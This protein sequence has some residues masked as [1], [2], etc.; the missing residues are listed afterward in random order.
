MVFDCIDAD[1][2]TLS[3]SIQSH[4]EKETV[5]VKS[6]EKQ[7]KNLKEMLHRLAALE[8]REE[9]REMRIA[10]QEDLIQQLQD[11]LIIVQGK[12]CQ[13][14]ECPVAGGHTLEGL[15]EQ[16]EEE[17]EGLEYASK[18]SYMTLPTAPLEL[19]DIITQDVLRFSTLPI[20][21]QEGVRECCWTRVVEF[22]DDLVEIAD[23]ERSKEPL[24]S[25]SSSSPRT[26]LPELEDQENINPIPIPPPVGNPPPYAVSG[27]HAV[28]SKGVPKSA[29]H[30][31]HRPLAQLQC[32]KATAGRLHDGDS[33]W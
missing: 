20:K 29:F 9:E 24:S 19:E 16:N 1:L 15:S 5:L 26:S 33:L 10:L 27:Q 21:E 4:W 11:E 2:V 22:M 8:N 13:C 17:E 12:V 25:E 18:C 28:C 23:D 7:Q 6:L 32:S 3:D 31:Y 30:P 14:H